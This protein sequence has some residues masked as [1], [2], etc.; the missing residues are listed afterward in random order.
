[1]ILTIKLVVGVVLGILLIGGLAFYDLD[2]SQSPI[3]IQE[4]KLNDCVPI[5]Y[6]GD[7]IEQAV[8]RY[9]K[10]DCFEGYEIFLEVN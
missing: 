6:R 4:T 10:Q 5:V 8:E 9:E 3:D 7:S 1:M 2:K